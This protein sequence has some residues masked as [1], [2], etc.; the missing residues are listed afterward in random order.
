[1]LTDGAFH[2][3]HMPAAAPGGPAHRGRVEG[4]RALLESPFRKDGH[5]SDAPSSGANLAHLVPVD[6]MLGQVK[7]PSLRDS[8]FT[9]PWGHGGTFTSLEDVVG[10]YDI[11][12]LTAGGPART[13]SLDPAVVSFAPSPEQLE[14]VVAFLRVAGGGP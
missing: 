6:A 7:T 10:H 8:V 4:V 14:A 5:F 2:D 12:E 11:E 3:I 9:G 13:G 1:M